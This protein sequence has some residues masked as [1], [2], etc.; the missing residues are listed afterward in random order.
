MES[1]KLTLIGVP[2]GYHIV[3]LFVFFSI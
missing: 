3:F 1:L 2:L